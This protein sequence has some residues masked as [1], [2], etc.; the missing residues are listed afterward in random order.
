MCYGHLGRL[1]DALGW[2]VK[3]KELLPEEAPEECF[4]EANNN[5]ELLQEALGEGLS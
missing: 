4:E 3:V 2:A 1:K 5:I